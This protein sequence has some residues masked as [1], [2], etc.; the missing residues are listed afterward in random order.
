MEK[1]LITG[2]SGL[3][4]YW[5]TKV[6]Y[7]KYKVIPTYLANKPYE[8]EFKNSIPMDITN[9]ESVRKILEEVK[10]DIIIHVAALTDVDLCEKDKQLAYN[11]NVNGTRNLV[12]ASKDVKLFVYI[13]TDYVFDGDRGNYKEDDIPNP[14]N[15]YGL[16]K[17]LGEEI[18]KTL[19]NYIII[20][21]SG[22]Y[23]YSPTGKKNFGIIAL[24][25][26]LNNENVFAFTDQILSPTYVEHLAIAI[27][28]LLETNL[29]EEIIHLCGDAISRY[30]FAKRLARFLGKEDLVIPTSLSSANFIAR[31]PRNSSL[32]REKQ[33]TY[34]LYEFSLDESLKRFVEVYYA[35]QKL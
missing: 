31:R 2:A 15:Y 16:S 3:L 26:L 23:G 1:I 33:K 21:T 14:I 35:Y 7:G 25:K 27:E 34:K 30:E 12:R 29:S 32:N 24:E 4:G 6:L 11:I 8:K 10:P 22:L 20:R 17:L 5:L 28:K 18:V 13:S 9:S 19:E